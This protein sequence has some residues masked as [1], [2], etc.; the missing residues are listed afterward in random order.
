MITIEFKHIQETAQ[1]LLFA[2][3]QDEERTAAVLV[4]DTDFAAAFQV[5]ENM[6]GGTFFFRDFLVDANTNKVITE[7]DTDGNDYTYEEVLSL[8]QFRL[9]ML[10]FTED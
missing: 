2:A 1:D 6:E 8:I 10:D 5:Y 4:P 3:E 7:A 9:N